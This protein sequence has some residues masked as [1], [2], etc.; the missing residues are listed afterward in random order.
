MASRSALPSLRSLARRPNPLPQHILINLKRKA[1]TLAA[2][3]SSAGTRAKNFLYGTGAVA[4]L[5]FSY[6]YI[7][8]TRAS[9]HQYAVVPLLRILNPDAETAHEN[10]TKLMRTLY[11]FGLHIRERSSQDDTGDLSI[12][13]FGHTLKNP[14][15]TSA[16]I[17]KHGEIPDALLALGGAVVEVG[18]CTPRAQDGNEKPRVF[19]LPGQKGMIN[20]YG[21]NSY[22]AEDMAMRLRERVRLFA[23][24][25]GLGVGAD[26]EKKILDGE[27][28]VPPG[29]LT[30]GKLLLVQI[31]KNKVTPENDIQAVI[32]D[33]V[34]CVDKL[35]RYADVLVVNVS[36]P[37]TPG[38]RTLQ[39]VE[40][41]TRLLA[42]V[43]AAARKV[44]RKTPPK[45]MVKV[46][47]DEDEDSQINGIC[48]AIWKSG[49]DGVIVGN[50]TKRRNDLIPE[51][52]RLSAHEQKILQEQGGYS[53]PGMFRRT[54]ALTK[55]YR[56]LLD[57]G[58]PSSSSSSNTDPEGKTNEV[59]AAV[60][61]HPT[62]EERKV[63]F[64]TGGI[65]NGAQAL[66]ILNA[67]ASVAQIYTAL[68]YGG[69]GTM[70][71]IKKEM[72]EVLKN[73]VTQQV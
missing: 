56:A 4:F 71:R 27:A 12:E 23:H 1:S 46:S 44:D 45:V 60:M 47:P 49:V 52:H 51:G 57:Q 3:S 29:S 42:G 68:T 35:A 19:R 64:A 16:G 9:I 53:G 61:P 13:V 38:L 62:N 14:I 69:A 8:D 15:G 11:S 73:G 66:E 17:D 58:P 24:R 33:H 40:P 28:G 55:R 10:G 25:N 54:L 59:A 70:T 2:D 65:T 63:I 20:R 48:E 41:L 26:A 50:T 43:V 5:G 7:T 72:R 37:N 30:E 67:G 39:S 22:G 31:A 32:D 21:L 34:Y 6:L 36:S 18:G